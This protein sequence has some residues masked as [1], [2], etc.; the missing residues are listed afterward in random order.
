MELY[1]KLLLNNKQFRL[2]YYARVKSNLKNK[3]EGKLKW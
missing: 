1:I 3:K 2:K